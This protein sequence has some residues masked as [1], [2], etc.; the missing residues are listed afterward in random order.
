[1]YVTVATFI[2]V[3]FIRLFQAFVSVE[4]GF[5]E[6]IDDVLAEKTNL[7]LQLPDV[8]SLCHSVNYLCPLSCCI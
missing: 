3:W 5:F 7:R 1:M 4:K 2:N 8:S 6:T